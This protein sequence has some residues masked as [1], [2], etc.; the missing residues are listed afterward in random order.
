M[1]NHQSELAKAF[2][3][4]GNLVAATCKNLIENLKKLPSTTFVPVSPPKTSRFGTYL[5]N[6][7]CE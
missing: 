1:N 5:L 4:N 7:M 3:E 2:S 6:L